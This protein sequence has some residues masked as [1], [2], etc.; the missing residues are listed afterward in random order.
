M[1]DRES[2]R[3]NYLRN[4]DYHGDRDRE[5]RC[6]REDDSVLG[7]VDRLMYSSDRKRA[8][9]EYRIVFRRKFHCCWEVEC[10]EDIL[11][12]WDDRGNVHSIEVF[13]YKG[14]RIVVEGN[15]RQGFTFP[16]IG[17]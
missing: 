11:S 9:E 16:S 4:L 7:L 3:R 5:Y 12:V 6:L 13:L 10:A 14:K 8:H 1:E 15:G 17:T 2:F